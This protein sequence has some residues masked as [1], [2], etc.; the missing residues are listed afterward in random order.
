MWKLKDQ[1]ITASIKSNI[2]SMVHEKPKGSLC[3]FCLTEKFRLLKHFNNE[4][5]LN[6]KLELIS[7][8]RH[9]NKLPVK[10]VEKG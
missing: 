9:E 1:K 10:S 8:C 4:H 3:K 2:M 7:N 5:L 6:K